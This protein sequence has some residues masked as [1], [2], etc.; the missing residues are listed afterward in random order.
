MAGDVGWREVEGGCLVGGGMV[1]RY[2]RV[3]LGG[4]GVEQVG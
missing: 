2:V 4:R 1:V 3:R